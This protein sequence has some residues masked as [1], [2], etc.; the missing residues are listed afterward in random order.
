MIKTNKLAQQRIKKLLLQDKI[1]AYDG[2]IDI[3]KSKILETVSS[4]MSVRSVD[5]DIDIK[6]NNSY[7]LNIV[8]DVIDIN[9][10]SS[11]S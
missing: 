4:Y 6:D 8:L 3:L 1:R 11:F 10:P 5:I 9:S 2:F 7:A